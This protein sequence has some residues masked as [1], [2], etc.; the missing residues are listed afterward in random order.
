MS[1]VKLV[2]HLS[3]W[4]IASCLIFLSVPA[5]ARGD[6]QQCIL[7]AIA[8][9]KDDARVADI[10][11]QCAARFSVPPL[12]TSD[13]RE[14]PVFEQGVMR[15]RLQM[16]IDAENTPFMFTPHLPNYFG[17]STFEPNQAPFSPLTEINDSVEN[18]EAVFQ[19]SFKAPIWRDMFGSGLNTYFAYTAKSWWQ[20]ANSEFSNPFR[21]TNYMPE[22]FVRDVRGKDVLGLDVVGWSLGVAHESNGR[23]QAL[24][25]SWNRVI[26]RAGIQ[27][28]DDVSLFGQLW[29]R[30]PD[31]EDDDNPNEYRFYGYGDVRAVWTPNKNTFTAMVRP[32]TEELSYELTWSY[33]VSRVFRV[34]ASYYN[35]FGE[36]LLDYDFDGRRFML[37]IALNDFI[38][39]Q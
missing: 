3:S 27:L 21:E 11:A 23:E 10:R 7:D 35:G 19:L 37:G 1:K 36:S 30:I 14:S 38:A 13:N 12:T 39:R 26:G 15:E 4:G 29:Y 9:A 22:V 8:S 34:Y 31:D 17:Y 24:S 16:E 32:G 28:H 25:R 2:S 20:V 18:Q 6:Y 33:P 5:F